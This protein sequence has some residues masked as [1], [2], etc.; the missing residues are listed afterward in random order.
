MSNSPKPRFAHLKIFTD[1]AR[2]SRKR[3]KALKTNYVNIIVEVAVA[4]HPAGERVRK[5]MVKASRK[6][7]K[8]ID[9][10]VLPKEASDGT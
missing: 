2:W 7:M 5:G 6:L 8:R 1:K 9:F 10:S 4:D 3:K